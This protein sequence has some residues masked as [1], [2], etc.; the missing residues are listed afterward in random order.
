MKTLILARNVLL[1]NHV[2][3]PR[4]FRRPTKGEQFLRTLHGKALL[5][6][7]FSSSPTKRLVETPEPHERQS[8]AW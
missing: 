6:P 4:K 5:E 7:L 8:C 3:T 1:E 2:R